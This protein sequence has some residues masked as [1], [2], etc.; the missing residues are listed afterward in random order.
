[1]KRV[2]VFR[3]DD[4]RLERAVEL[5]D[6]LGVEPVAD[7]MLAVSPTGTTPR[8][9]ADY[10]ILTSKTGV[11]LAAEAG[12]TPERQ[13]CAIG[14]ATADALRKAGYRVDHVPEKFS[15]AGLVASLEAEVPGR[16]VEVAR[17]DHGS[18]VLTDGL[19]AAGAYVHETVLYELV[20]PPDAGES[21]ELAAEGDLAGAL[22]T[23][24]LTVENFLAAA[25]E[26][27]VQTAAIAGLNDAAVGAI[28]E[29]TRETATRAGIA[30]DVVPPVAEFE[31]LARKTAERLTNDGEV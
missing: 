6:S 4:E 11:E 30:V 20:R 28:G 22:F 23:S 2:A 12:W 9:D 13:V 26:R 10:A 31:A 29:P 3:P 5:L 24:S 15:S 18:R 19:E 14:T 27:G 1:M 8:E 7:P 25:S 17:S 21:A 16:R